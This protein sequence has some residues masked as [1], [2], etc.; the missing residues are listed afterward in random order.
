MGLIEP[1]NGEIIF[2]D[3]KTSNDFNIGYM[4]QIN[5]LYDELTVLQHLQFF[6]RMYGLNE[7]IKRDSAVKNILKTVSL[8]GF[9]NRKISKL[10][11]GEKQRVS[12]GIAMMVINFM[13]DL[14]SHPQCKSIPRT[15]A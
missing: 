15:N 7:N 1:L 9:E 5:A 2:H 13:N 4:P 11:G 3:Q 12:L 6:A 8:D 14:A 10:S